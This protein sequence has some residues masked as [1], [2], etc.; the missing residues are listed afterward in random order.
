ME[1]H[2]KILLQVIERA[3]EK[4]LKFNKKETQFK[5]SSVKYLGNVLSEKRMAVDPEKVKQT[6]SNT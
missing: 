2:D 4:L 5:E 6:P 1:D 3:K